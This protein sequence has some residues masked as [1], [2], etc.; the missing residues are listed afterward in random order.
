[1][2]D[3]KLFATMRAELIET[4][5]RSGCFSELPMV[6]IARRCVSMSLLNRKDILRTFLARDIDDPSFQLSEHVSTCGLFGLAVW[7]AS[8]VE[9]ELLHRPYEIG[10]AI[11]WIMHIANDLQA[12]RYPKR[13][14]LPIEGA[15]MHYYTKR[16]S[17][18]DHVEFCLRPP[19]PH[20]FIAE[21]AGGGRE[22]CGIGDG[23]GD[24]RWNLGRPLQCWYD[25]MALLRGIYQ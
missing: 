13:D 18:D 25:P 21:H 11:S 5:R 4:Y 6:T 14:G 2:T 3:E 1:M 16:P 17:K 20:T 8:G 12:I 22:H 15:L 7:Y 23:V 9:H 19:N 24:I 10:M